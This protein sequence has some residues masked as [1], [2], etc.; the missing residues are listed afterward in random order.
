MRL[1]SRHHR[2]AT[3]S[4]AI[5]RPTLSRNQSVQLLTQAESFSG[6]CIPKITYNSLPLKVLDIDK[7]FSK[8][9][10]TNYELFYHTVLFP[11]YIK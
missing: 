3:L 9:T 1:I 5:V 8:I 4:I 2:K 11:K 7:A 10:P 6:K